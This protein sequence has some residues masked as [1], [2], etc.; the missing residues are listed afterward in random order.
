MTAKIH[1]S[2][3][4]GIMGIQLRTPLKPLDM[5]WCLR[6]FQKGGVQSGLPLMP[7]CP[8]KPHDTIVLWCSRGFRKEKGLNKAIHDAMSLL[9]WPRK[10]SIF[11][12]Q[13][14][15]CFNWM[16]QFK[17]RQN[18]YPTS[19]TNDKQIAHVREF[20]DWFRTNETNQSENQHINTFF[21]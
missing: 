18:A 20:S 1:L 21:R 7:K 3:P 8:L 9:D 17:V 4:R 10:F 11:L 13:L 5:L 14:K 6:G 15:N 19:S 12:G 16:K 2:S